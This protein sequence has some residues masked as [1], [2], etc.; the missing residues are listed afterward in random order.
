MMHQKKRPWEDQLTPEKC[1]GSVLNRR[2]FGGRV[3]IGHVTKLSAVA[4]EAVVAVARQLAEAG[5][6]LTV[7]PATDLFLLGRTA[8]RLV[9]RGLAPAL[10]LQAKGVTIAVASNNILNPFTPDGFK[11]AESNCDTT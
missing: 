2:G 4:P 7:M 11:P 3:S 1:S 9:P 5:I 10:L 6:G 8:D